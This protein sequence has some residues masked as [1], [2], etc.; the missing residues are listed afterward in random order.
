[1]AHG[2]DTKARSLT[3]GNEERTAPSRKEMHHEEL[4]EQSGKPCYSLSFSKSPDCLTDFYYLLSC[5]LLRSTPY[6]L[7]M[8]NTSTDG[9]KIKCHSFRVSE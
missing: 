9:I 5:D 8:Y 6:T 4:L 1:M 3:G 7:T 2:A